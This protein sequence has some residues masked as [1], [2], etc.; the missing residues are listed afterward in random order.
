MDRTDEQ[1]TCRR[2]ANDAQLAGD[3]DYASPVAGSAIVCGERV[4]REHL[5]DGRAGSEP[6]AAVVDAVD[7]VEFLRGGVVGFLVVAENAWF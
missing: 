7:E 3:V 1:L 4:L 6:A 2:S 5:L